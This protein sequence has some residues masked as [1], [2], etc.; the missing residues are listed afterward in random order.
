MSVVA[1]K[2]TAAPEQDNARPMNGRVDAIDQGRVFGWAFDPAAPNQRLTIRVILDGSVIAEAV[3]DRNR[4]DLKR[5]GIGDGS[6]A[7]EIAL[8]EAAAARTGDLVVTAL[9]GRGSEQRLRVPRPDEQAAEALI[10]APLTKVLDKLDILMAAQRQL[11][12]SQRSLLRTPNDVSG[13][14]ET[15]GLTA[16]GDAVANLRA[17]VAQRLDDL[18]VHLMRLDGVVAAMEKN[19]GGLQKR[20][21][22]ELKPLLLL[23][24]VLVGFAA[25]AALALFTGA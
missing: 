4:P 10:A 1:E 17:E 24:F 18:D 11:Q 8:P 22:T 25:G 14:I 16:I 13:E 9:D 20:S 6:H 21:N 19:L 12:V 5:N 7:F 3:A 23:L 15:Q 2:S